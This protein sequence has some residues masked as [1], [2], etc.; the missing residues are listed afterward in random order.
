MPLDLPQNHF[1]LFGLPHTLEV[2]EQQLTEQY[3]SLQREL[4]P[5]RFAAAGAQ[6]RRL[7]AQAAAQVNAAYRVLG[8]PFERASYLLSLHGITIDSEQ[9]TS[10]DGEFLMHQME[11][12][13][14]LEEIAEPAQADAFGVRLAGETDAL[15]GEF[16]ENCATQSW[17]AAREAL[18]KLSFYRRLQQQLERSREGLAAG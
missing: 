18:L 6:E 10:N 13:E 11:L 7:A 3:R 5:D 8:D 9:D 15:W 12:R 4:H 16:G 14:Q 17:Q 2:D 1:E